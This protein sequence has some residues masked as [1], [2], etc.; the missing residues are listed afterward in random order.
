MSAFLCTDKHV[1]A[2]AILADHHGMCDDPQAL[3]FTLRALNNA[4]LRDRYNDEGVPLLAGAAAIQAREQAVAWLNS[5][6][7]HAHRE[8]VACLKYQCAEGPCEGR[9]GWHLLDALLNKLVGIAARTP[10]TAPV[11][12]WAI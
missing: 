4:A 8:I 3:A 5:T 2:V 12:V 11:G 9:P 6:T 1:Y 7:A 10:G